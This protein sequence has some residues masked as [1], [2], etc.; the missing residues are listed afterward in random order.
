MSWQIKLQILR[1]RGWTD[2]Q[3]SVDVGDYLGSRGPSA[4]SVYR[5]RTGKTKPAQVYLGALEKLFDD[6]VDNPPEEKEVKNENG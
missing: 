5:W 3:V 2:E 6:I 4:M 1:L